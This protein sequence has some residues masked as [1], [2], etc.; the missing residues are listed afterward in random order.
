VRA[1]FQKSYTPLT[2]R[3]REEVERGVDEDSR[4]QELPVGRAFFDGNGM[5]AAT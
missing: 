5:A 4:A 1:A 2:N 3:L